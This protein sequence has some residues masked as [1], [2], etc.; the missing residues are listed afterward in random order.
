MLLK[1]DVARAFDSVAW[2]FLISVLRQRG[3]GPR[4]IGWI[5]LLLRTASTRV[6]VNGS[7]GNAFFHGRGLRQGDPISPMMFI[8]AMDVLSVLFCAVEEW[9]ALRIFAPMVFVT[10]CRSTPMTWW[11]LLGRGLRSCTPFALSWLAS[12]APPGSS[13]LGLPLSIAK[14]RKQDVQPILDKL[15]KKLSFWKARL[16]SREGRVAYVRFVMTASVIY[17]LMA[18]DLE[19]WVLRAIDKV[20][21]G[22][23][24][25]GKDDAQG[26]HCI[27]AWHA[28]CKPKILGGLGLH[29]LR[30]LN[31][32]L[33]SR[34]VWFQKTSLDKPWSGLSF[35]VRSDA[36]A[37]FTA[38][39]TV[40]VR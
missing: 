4:F 1:M 9:G 14:L 21:R 12:A 30:W 22:F 19:P 31:A 7:P 39:V 13:Y 28:V 32:A 27:V 2:T 20:R 8:I 35:S 40:S 34:W 6:L 37:L 38:S 25:V 3:F 24:W 16:M 29:N 10:V 5:I 15:S 23:L 26:G 36:H 18:L 11:F 33:R 17:Q